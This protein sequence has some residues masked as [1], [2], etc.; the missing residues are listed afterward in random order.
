MR[1]IKLFEEFIGSDLLYRSSGFLYESTLKDAKFYMEKIYAKKE[2][3]EIKDLTQDQKF[4]ALKNP[5][6]QE[7]RKMLEEKN[8]LGYAFLFVKFH[9]EMRVP[10][11]T[12][13]PKIDQIDLGD[14]LEVDPNKI[15][16]ADLKTLLVVL[17]EKKN[18]IAKLPNPVPK[19]STMEDGFENLI[20]DIRGVAREE[21]AKWLIDRLY[22][23]ARDGYRKATKGERSELINAA[24]ALEDL[25]LDKEGE[26]ISNRFLSYIKDYKDFT[27][28]QFM[29]KLNQFLSSHKN[30]EANKKAKEVLSL[31]PEA[32]II[33]N[34]DGYL[35]LSIRTEQAQIKLCSLGSWCINRGWWNRYAGK[36]GLQIN[37]FDFNRDVSDS[38]FLVG[39]TIK[40]E[41]FRITDCQ[42]MT[43]QSVRRSSDVSENFTRLGYPKSL[44]DTLV[45]ALP[46]E[47][48]I[49]G[50]LD[51]ME[52]IDKDKIILFLLGL[53]KGKQKNFINQASFDKMISII[54]DVLET[55]NRVTKNEILNHCKEY[56]L[57]G[58]SNLRIFDLIFKPGE[59]TNQDI[60]KIY[61]STLDGLE[62]V[63]FMINWGKKTKN[64]V[65]D[66]DE[67]QKI[68]KE[69]PEI[70][71][72]IKRKM[73]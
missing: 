62:Q 20:D 61:D 30:L 63:E 17:S 23:P 13:Y 64:T 1:V 70:L 19:Y 32:G 14:S 31:E 57:V 56:G 66:L 46:I 9:F 12:N 34:N 8:Q 55:G 65:K 59:Y 10:I 71:S 29:V 7:I 18:T 22:G 69:G 38:M 16:I 50:I 49:K 4:E 24:Y 43:N 2:K 15:Q 37:I 67:I 21:R 25:G 53:D 42:D 5:A 11:G 52:L 72:E 51:E 48:A 60:Q 6:Y 44:V 68:V 33:Y 27:Y 35:V 28:Q 58:A 39:T 40:Y 36:T 3:I 41:G 73:K 54:L 47:V 26:P 45:K